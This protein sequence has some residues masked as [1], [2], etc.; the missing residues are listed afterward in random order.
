VNW[1]SLPGNPPYPSYAGNHAAIGTSQATILALFFGRD[2]IRFDQAWEGGGGAT[3]SY[4]GFMAMANEDERSRVYGISFQG[5][6]GSVR[7]SI[8]QIEQDVALCMP[9]GG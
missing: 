8:G 1:S 2:D 7:L 6:G 5:K 4:S 3:R 9:F